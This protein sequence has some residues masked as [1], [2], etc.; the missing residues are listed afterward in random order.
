MNRVNVAEFGH[1]MTGYNFFFTT[2][3]SKWNR[4]YFSKDNH[5]IS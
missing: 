5:I 4:S 3:S 2:R 1:V